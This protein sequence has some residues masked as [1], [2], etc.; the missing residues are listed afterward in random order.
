[1]FFDAYCQ[2]AYA[3]DALYFFGPAHTSARLA[4][5][6]AALQAASRLRPDAGETHLPRGQNLYWAYGDYDGAQAELQIAHQTLPSD[7]R[8]F[9][10]TG[11]I[12]RRQGRWEESTRNPER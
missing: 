2:L 9:R 8:I 1:S 7:A 12:Q 10:L 11:Y 5:A 4:S 6:E 3:H